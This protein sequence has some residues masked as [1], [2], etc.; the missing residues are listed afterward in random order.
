MTEFAMRGAPGRY[1]LTGMVVVVLSLAACSKPA[2]EQNMIEGLEITVVSKGDGPAV[3]EGDTAV[4]HY[5]GWLHDAEAEDGRGRKFDSSR[6]RNAT[7]PVPVGAG[8][9]IRGWDLGLPGMQVG[10]VRVLR[11]APDLAYGSRGAG[12]VIPPDAT[13]IFEIELVEIQ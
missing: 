7:F 3:A 13:L 2:E 1:L 4:V 11:I 5:T 6:D 9:V 10:E 8:R 12:G